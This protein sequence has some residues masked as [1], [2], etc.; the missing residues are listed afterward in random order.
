MGFRMGKLTVTTAIAAIMILLNGCGTL[1]K[2]DI[3]QGN[4]I[5]AQMVSELQP[6]MTRREVVRIMGT[7]LIHD[8]F[9]SN[10]WDF[11]HSL[12]DGKTGQVTQYRTSLIFTDD[13][14]SDISTTV[15]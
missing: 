12:K 7:P 2:P 8:P 6:G 13:Q 11:Y 3:Q 9:N 10:R 15:E 14:L 1:Y 4:Q 5:T